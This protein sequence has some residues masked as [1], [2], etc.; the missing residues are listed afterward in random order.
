MPNTVSFSVDASWLAPKPSRHTSP[1]SEFALD[2]QPN[3]WHNCDGWDGEVTIEFHKLD[4]SVSV[5]H[6]ECEHTFA[7]NRTIDPARGEAVAPELCRKV[8]VTV[9]DSGL[10]GRERSIDITTYE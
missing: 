6:P 10:P 9:D 8:V 2:C 1:L 7:G 5:Y 4:G 3:N